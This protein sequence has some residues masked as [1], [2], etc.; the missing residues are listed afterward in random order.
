LASRSR[1]RNLKP[2][3]RPSKF[4]SRLRAW[5]VTHSPRGLS[6]DPG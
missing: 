6:G 5:W 2:S 3:T 4:I 1:I